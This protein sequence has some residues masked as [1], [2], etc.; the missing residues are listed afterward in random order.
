MIIKPQFISNRKLTLLRKL[1][2][3]KYRKKER[4]FVA[5]GAR[6]VQQIIKN[7]RINVHELFFDEGQHFWRQKTWE[8]LARSIGFSVIAVKKFSDIS[9]T[10]NPQGVIAL[11]QMPKEVAV[12]N[13]A[14]KDGIM[15]AADALQDPGNL[16]TIIRTACWFG[17]QGFLSGKG[18]VDLFHPKVV[19]ATAGAAGVIPYANCSL[20]ESL[21]LFEKQG[22]QIILLDAGDSATPLKKVK[23]TDKMMIVIGNEAHGIDS[24]LFTPR[25]KRIRIG[26]PKNASVES[27]NAG[28]ALGI[29]LHA[30]SEGS[31]RQT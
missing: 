8:S 15:I 2:L 22:W 7:G 30:L 23:K 12:E 16:G 13:L 14:D 21:S 3:K 19:R 5:E 17:A 10:E 25:R 6:A 28:V 29:S 11:C 20:Q 31:R 24:S 26:S 1:N 9:D 27:L 18:T 4:L